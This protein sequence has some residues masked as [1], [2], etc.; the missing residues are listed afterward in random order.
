MN[1]IKKIIF[2][3]YDTNI[4][5]TC[6]EIFLVLVLDDYKF[7]ISNIYNISIPQFPNWKKSIFVSQ[8]CDLHRCFCID[9]RCVHILNIY[10][11][12]YIFTLYALICKYQIGIYS[13]RHFFKK[14]SYI[15]VCSKTLRLCNK[16]KV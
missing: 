4:L 11:Y 15:S 3:I 12:I 7:S 14:A 13:K 2:E 8:Q 10:I 9:K 6:F 5:K 1:L 16:Q